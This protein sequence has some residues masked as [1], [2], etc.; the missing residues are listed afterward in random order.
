MDHIIEYNID[1]GLIELGP[2]I[3]LEIL[4][5]ITHLEDLQQFLVLCRKTFKLQNHQRLLRMIQSTLQVTPIFIIKKETQ[6]KLQ[7]MKFIHSNN[8]DNC[9][10]AIDPIIME[11]I[12]RIDIIFKNTGG[13]NISIGIADA[14]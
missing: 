8:Y 11:G 10:I 9:T 2:D 5:E 12:V 7:G 14:S 13:W 3:L 4:S 6:G 1:G